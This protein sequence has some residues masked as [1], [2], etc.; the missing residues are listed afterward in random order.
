LCRNF[1]SAGIFYFFWGPLEK[2]PSKICDIDKTQSHY[3][4]D[5]D[6]ENNNR[7]M[8]PIMNPVNHKTNFNI[9]PGNCQQDPDVNML[10]VR[11]ILGLDLPEFSMVKPESGLILLRLIGTTDNC[12]F[13]ESENMESANP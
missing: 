12:Q 9:Y 7:G 8:M 3:H 10:S 4:S 13:T 1:V 6:L 11:Q 5:R 2:N